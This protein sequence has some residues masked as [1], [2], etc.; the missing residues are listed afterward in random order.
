M[1]QPKTV[2]YLSL[3]AL[4][5]WLLCHMSISRW[6]G[7]EAMSKLSALIYEHFND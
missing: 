4:Q 3:E 6:Q 1:V 5:V 2:K 7:R